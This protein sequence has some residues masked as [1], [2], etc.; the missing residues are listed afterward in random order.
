MCMLWIYQ[1]IRFDDQIQYVAACNH[2]LTKNME[3]QG[4]EIIWYTVLHQFYTWNQLRDTTKSSIRLS[5]DQLVSGAKYLITETFRPASSE[6]VMA[7]RGTINSGPDQT[8]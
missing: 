3:I 2:S 4:S 6:V 1:Y 5:C 7:A 8:L